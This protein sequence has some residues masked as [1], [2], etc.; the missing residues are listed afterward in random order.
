M[1]SPTFLEKT[2]HFVITSLGETGQ[3]PH[4]TEIDWA[5]GLTMEEGS[6]A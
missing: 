2:G 4:Y 6:S 1:P 3:A 5:M